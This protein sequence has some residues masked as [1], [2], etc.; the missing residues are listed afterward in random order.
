MKKT[1]LA[2]IAACALCCIPLAIP[3][4]AGI[5]VFG[6]QLLRTPLSLES[7]FC[8]LLAALVVSLLVFAM[9]RGK[10]KRSQC[11]SASCD[12]TGKCG[13]RATKTG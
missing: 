5:S 12:S 7:V 4:L 10:A 13:C 2:I 6:L 8:A 3:A 11:H 9:L 1:I